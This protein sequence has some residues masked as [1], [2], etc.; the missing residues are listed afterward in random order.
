MDVSVVSNNEVIKEAIEQ[1]RNKVEL[2]IEG[3][4]AQKD[5]EKY[6]AR[7]RAKLESGK[8]LSVKEMRYLKQYNP[9]LY[10]HAVRI[11]IK[12]KSVEERL[13]HARSKQEV[14]D[15]QCE[16][17]A[18]IS[19]KDPVKNYMV[20]AVCETVKAFKETEGYK[21]LPETYTEAKKKENRGRNNKVRNDDED[22]DGESYFITYER[23]AN[24]YQIAY[25]ESSANGTKTG[26]LQGN[27]VV[28]N[29]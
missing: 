27:K 20:A 25:T 29:C 10:M 19:K 13:K 7:I 3:E 23:C 4:D 16:A 12:R 9:T 18:A 26:L 28:I 5:R 6:E 2:G 1:F 8:R 21:R 17:I 14:Q 22:C 11:E 24:S 15:I